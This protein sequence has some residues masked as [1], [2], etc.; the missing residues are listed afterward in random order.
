VELLFKLAGRN[1][2]R[3]RGQ[4]LVIGTILFLGAALMTVGNG[5]ISGMELGL[6]KT[7]VHG[8]TGDLVL[9]SDKQ[10]SENVFL[11]MMGRAV[12]PIHNY[13]AIRTALQR[14]P[15][16]AENLPVGKNMAMVLNEEDGP[17]TFLYVLGVDFDRYRKAFPGNMEL[18]EGKFPESGKPALLLPTGARK[19]IHGETNVWFIP[20]GSNLDA[21]HLEGEAKEHA[22]DLNV[23]SSVVLMGFNENNTAT[24]IR[25]D[26]DGIFRYSALNTIFGSFALMDIESYRQCLG[27]FLAS[28]RSQ[29]TVTGQD[30]ALFALEGSGLDEL[31]SGDSLLV[32]SRSSS[33]SRNRPGAGRPGAG[34][35]KGNR[36]HAEVAG[37]AQPQASRVDGAGVDRDRVD[38]DRGDFNLVLV[39]LRPGVDPDR[40]LKDVND[41]LRAG[42]LGVHAVPWKK[43]L[44]PVGSMAGLIKGALF[45]FV[46]FLFVVAVIIIVNTLTMAALERTPELGMMRAIG[47]RKGFIGA[48]FLAETAMLSAIFGGAGIALG[49]CVVEILAL[50]KLSSDNDMLQLFF[51]GDKFRPVL[52]AGD[53]GL[54]LM[55]LTF[56]ALVAVCYPVLRARSVTPLDAVYKE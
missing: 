47:A 26:V 39:L 35:L 12:E 56:V 28:E 24:D 20:K 36:A 2:W 30:S 13:P 37:S 29:G 5:I 49:A 19:Q 16:V 48:M 31:F 33:A 15:L 27:Y 43:A 32:E 34:A 41:S 21:S 40:A 46:S 55:Q 25:L 42:N 18:I 10:E 51:G 8:F 11:E 22:A 45:L 52:S 4:S 7:V 54:A 53:I 6:Q 1:I 9:V 50:L 23:K 3:H 17:S 14:H 38:L 44:G